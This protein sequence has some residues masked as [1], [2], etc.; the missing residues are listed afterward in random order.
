[1]VPADAGKRISVSVTATTPGYPSVTRW[2]EQTEVVSGEAM[3]FGQPQIKGEFQTGRLLTVEVPAF[4]P[5]ELD[6]TYQWYR[7]GRPITGATHSA[8]VPSRPDVGRSIRVE[9]TVSHLGYNTISTMSPATRITVRAADP[10]AE[11]LVHTAPGFTKTALPPVP[12]ANTLRLHR[13]GI[14][15]V[16]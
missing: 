1:L 10:P 5:D 12:K 4:Y 11:A 2:T 9:V 3:V 13:P 6:V 7:D 15:R 14:A 16:I 8:F